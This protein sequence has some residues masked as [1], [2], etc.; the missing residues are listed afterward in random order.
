MTV[1][2]LLALNPPSFVSTVIVQVPPFFAVT[3]PLLLTVAIL[4][5]ELFHVTLLSVALSGLTVAVSFNVSQDRYLPVSAI[6]I[7]L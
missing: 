7:R 5:L 6:R 1:I 2:L 4:V 3:T